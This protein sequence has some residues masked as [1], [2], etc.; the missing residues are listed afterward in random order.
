ML[1]I[2][3]IAAA[4]GI[5]KTKSSSDKLQK[6]SSNCKCLKQSSKSPRHPPPKK[7]I[8]ISRPFEAISEV[9]Y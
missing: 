2:V 8:Q 5:R 1:N 6:N 3:L 4:L 9:N 7:K